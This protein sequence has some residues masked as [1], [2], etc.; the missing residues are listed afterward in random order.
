[1]KG[2]RIEEAIGL[3]ECLKE[4]RGTTIGTKTD[5]I[6]PLPIPALFRCCPNLKVAPPSWRVLAG[7]KP[8]L[9][10][11]LGQRRFSLPLAQRDE[12]S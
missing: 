5:P 4:S 7:W 10:L 3:D 1:M 12:S 6:A 9:Q 8:A 2:K 11:K